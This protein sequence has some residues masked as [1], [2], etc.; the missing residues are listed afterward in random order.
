[1]LS[2]EAQNIFWFARYMER[3]ENTARLI[4]VN[5]NLMLDLPRH[6]QV[7]WAPLVRITGNEKI[8][9]SL[10]DKADEKS[11]VK[12]LVSDESNP[13]SIMSSLTFARE[14]ARTIREILPREAWEAINSLYIGVKERLPRGLAER[15][16]FEFMKSI[17]SDTQ[18][19]A[20]L[21][22]GTL[23]HDNVYDFLCLGCEI[24]RADMTTRIIDVRSAS[25][26]AASSGDFVPY[27]NI[28]WTSVLK[29]LSAYQMYRRHERG[30][31]TAAAVLDFLVKDRRFP[32]SLRHCVMEAKACLA[33]LPRH[34]APLKASGAVIRAAS[35]FSSRD[36]TRKRLTL[37]MDGY[38]RSLASLSDE[39]SRTYFL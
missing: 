25:L 33:R 39:I 11:V 12:F 19:L 34:E 17:I 31:V 18:H 9:K 5:T 38:Q 23:T 37:L 21:L 27:E 28:Q 8:F 29:S 22:A 16:R 2:R 20:G 4:N 7:G 32:R 26:L 15:S 1:M 14:N 13:G 36:V 35:G 30:P 10:Y 6:V 3:A 24:E